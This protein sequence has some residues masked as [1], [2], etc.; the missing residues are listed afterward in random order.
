[1][2][3][4]DYREIV[5]MGA[6]GL[7][8]APCRHILE[9]GAGKGLHKDFGSA[10]TNGPR[11]TLHQRFD[12]GDAFPVMSQTNGH[13][14]EVVFQHGEHTALFRL[15]AQNAPVTGQDGDIVCDA[16]VHLYAGRIGTPRAG[17]A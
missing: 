14:M 1:M 10:R 15:D 9:R 13:A 4:G 11:H 16:R 2:G 5:K 6:V 12:R 3:R 17:H 8:F 7:L